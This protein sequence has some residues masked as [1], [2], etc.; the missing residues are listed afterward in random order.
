MSSEAKALAESKEFKHIC[1]EILE[2]WQDKYDS[3]GKNIF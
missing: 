3:T 1:L 2:S